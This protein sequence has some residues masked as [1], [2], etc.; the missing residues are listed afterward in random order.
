MFLDNK[1]LGRD[2]CVI[3]DLSRREG[4][5]ESAISRAAIQRDPKENIKLK[6]L[7]Y[8]SKRRRGC[9]GRWNRE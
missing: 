8:I 4:Y 3:R 5:G 9:T 1:G 7:G 2:W 6:G